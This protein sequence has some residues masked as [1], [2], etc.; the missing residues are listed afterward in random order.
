MRRRQCRP[1]RLP[2]DSSSL[3]TITLPLLLRFADPFAGFNG[4]ERFR[5]NVSNLGGMLSDVQLEITSFEETAEGVD[6][7]WCGAPGVEW[8]Q[9]A[10]CPPRRAAS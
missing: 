8:P 1:P 4:T 6:T 10:A 9:R 3:H 2:T 5:R 7:K